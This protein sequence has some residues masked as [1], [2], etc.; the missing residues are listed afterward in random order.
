ML[1]KFL[2]LCSEST[3]G[4]RDLGWVSWHLTSDDRKPGTVSQLYRLSWVKKKRL[5]SSK[6]S[7]FHP[8][9]SAV[10]WMYKPCRYQPEEANTSLWSCSLFSLCRTGGWLHIL[11]VLRFQK[12]NSEHYKLLFPSTYF[13][14]LRDVIHFYIQISLSAFWRRNYFSKKLLM[15]VAVTRAPCCCNMPVA[16]NHHS[17]RPSVRCCS[18]KLTL[19]TRTGTDEHLLQQ[20]VQF[21]ALFNPSESRDCRSKTEADLVIEVQQQE[22]NT[23]SCFYRGRKIPPKGN[24]SLSSSQHKNDVAVINE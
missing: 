15:E 8:S 17:P 22:T 14:H 1:T 7:V 13:I 18:F 4:V 23:E 20:S 21:T 5:V 2:D 11:G 6:P 24:N 3:A 16:H 9:M 19:Y 10:A 12:T